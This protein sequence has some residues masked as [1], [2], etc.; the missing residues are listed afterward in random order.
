MESQTSTETLETKVETAKALPSSAPAHVVEEDAETSSFPAATVEP[1]IET[2]VD[3]L[4][5]PKLPPVETLEAAVVEGPVEPTVNSPAEEIQTKDTDSGVSY[6]AKEEASIHVETLET[7][8]AV[9]V[10]PV[11][12]TID[13]T[14]ST[15]WSPVSLSHTAEE[16]ALIETVE[17]AVEARHIHVETLESRAAAVAEGPVEPP[18]DDVAAQKVRTKSTD[19]AVVDISHT[20]KVEP[21]I[22][23]T[24]EAST[25]PVET[26][27]SRAAVVEGP[28]DVSAQKVQTNS[29]DWS[30][31]SLSHTAEEELLIETV[32][33]AVEARHFPVETLES[34]AAAVV[35]EGPVE[36]TIDDVAAQK[37]E[38]KSTDW[39]PVNLSAEEEPLVETTVETSTSPVSE[40]SIETALIQN[41]Q[42]SAPLPL[43][44]ES[45]ESCLVNVAVEE[46][47]SKCEDRTLESVTLHVDEAL[48]ASLNTDELLRTSVLKEQAQKQL[49]DLLV[50]TGLGAENKAAETEDSCEDEREVLTKVLSKW[51]SVSEDLHELEGG[52]ELLSH[53]PAVLSRSP[54]R[55]AAAEQ[56]DEEAV[57]L[58]SIT[59][60]KVKAEALESEVLREMRNTLEKEAEE[61]SGEKRREVEDMVASEE[62]TEA[63]VTESLPEELQTDTLMEE[64]LVTEG[65]AGPEVGGDV[66]DDLDPVQRLF[67]EKIKEYNMR[68]LD[69][70]LSEVEPEYEKRLSE[71][72]AKLQRLY[73][74]G[75]V[76]SFPQFTF[77]APEMD[78][79]SK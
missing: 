28:V 35:A 8:A 56:T 22:E 24:V 25:C 14:K 34:R 32:E 13:E 61:E 5:E 45:T 21:I 9:V 42:E 66:W 46:S 60:L 76:S 69:G 3:S 18:I 52:S 4:A 54:G 64:L 10:G 7:E 15:D 49:Q 67:L 47:V 62:T 51:D 17:P 16:E 12:P 48:V 75:D 40:A 71:E 36:A 50:Q 39:S 29:T 68:R 27:E 78:Q 74:G 65:P 58:E 44:N 77:S 30:P 59:L 6:G 37:V 26:L 43:N 19:S 55:G 31:V 41:A 72:T 20:T 57:T 1:T 33:P 79:D 63:Q 2:T 53:V 70:G 23:T 38:T 11:E 73:G